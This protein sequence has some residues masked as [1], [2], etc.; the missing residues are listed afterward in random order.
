M[1]RQRGFTLVELLV[2]IGIIAVLI[3]ILLP[4]LNKAREQ[5][6]QV[7][8]LSN[9]RQ[10]G[11]ASQMFA[12]EHQQFLPLAGVLFGMPP[13]YAMPTP[14]ALGDISQRH[15]TYYNSGGYT[16]PMPFE[17]ALAPYLGQPNFR[18]DST[19]NLQP[20]L[21]SGYVRH[22]FTCPSQQNDAYPPMI[23][24]EY[25][26]WTVRL[27]CSYGFNGEALGWNSYKGDKSGVKDHYRARGNVSRMGH[28]P[29]DT[30]LFCDAFPRAT[31]LTSGG[32]SGTFY[33]YKLNMTLADCFNG[34]TNPKPTNA[35]A[36][37]YDQFDLNRHNGK[38]NIL[39][40][41][42]HA[43]KFDISPQN[44]ASSLT[45]VQIDPGFPGL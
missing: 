34:E 1:R 38:I 29:A 40:L 23:Q 20:D 31:S 3:S 14:Q 10:I 8:C 21:D 41:D 26:T 17:A 18:T 4:A 33:V 30:M 37:A 28:Q 36:G 24:I 7:Q 16:R 5:A 11:T 45:S 19:F 9:L 32:A 15:Y 43:E 42:Y 6:K 13:G 25:S 22:V 2:V 12:N 44:Q 27:H 39:F 35:D